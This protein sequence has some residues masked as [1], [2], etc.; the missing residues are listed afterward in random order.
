MHAAG[1]YEKDR[2]QYEQDIIVL[3]QRV[4]DGVIAPRDGCRYLDEVNRRLRT[5]KS[6]I[7]RDLKELADYYRNERAKVSQNTHPWLT[8][9]F[10]A[11][12]ASRARAEVRLAIAQEKS[13]TMGP[14]ERVKDD[15][16]SLMGWV[17]SHR[18]YMKAGYLPPAP[19]GE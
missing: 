6:E 15:I 19:D 7:I 8:A 4:R 13:A 17:R 2:Q 1:D 14:Y 12:A 16:N 5:I 9:F 11:H 18:E 3:L 10:G